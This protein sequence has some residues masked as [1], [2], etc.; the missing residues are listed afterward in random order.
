MGKQSFMRLFEPDAT[1]EQIRRIF[2]ERI[3]DMCET[4]GLKGCLF[5]HTAMGLGPEDDELRAAL[6]KYMKGMSKAF[7]TGL[8][9][10]QKRGEVRPDVDVRKAGQMLTSMMFGLVV[11]GR[12]GMT[13]EAMEGIVDSTLASLSG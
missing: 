2:R 4:Q 5:I 11:L 6:R 3:E 8:E 13:R 1:L 10:A 9:S 7:A 12:S